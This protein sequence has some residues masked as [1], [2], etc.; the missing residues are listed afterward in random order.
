MNLFYNLRNKFIFDQNGIVT[1]IFIL[2]R[3]GLILIVHFLSLSLGP[4]D[5]N[6]CKL[7]FRNYPNEYIFV[8]IP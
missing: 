8:K 1:I 7:R 2:I 3:H 5:L 6:S 4:D